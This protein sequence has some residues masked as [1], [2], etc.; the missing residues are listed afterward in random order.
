MAEESAK[1]LKHLSLED[2]LRELGATEKLSSIDLFFDRFHANLQEG[3]V[4]IIFSLKTHHLN[5]EVSLIFL[6]SK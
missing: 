6:V 1:K 3:Q 2:A 4:R 5:C